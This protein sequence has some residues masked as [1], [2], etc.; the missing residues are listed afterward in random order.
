MDLGKA[1][2]ISVVIDIW[3]GV[4]NWQNVAAKCS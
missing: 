3:D 1:D 2:E 4:L